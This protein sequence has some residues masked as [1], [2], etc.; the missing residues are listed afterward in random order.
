MYISII[1]IS[2]NNSKRVYIYIYIYICIHTHFYLVSNDNMEW[3]E[4]YH[5]YTRVEDTTLKLLWKRGCWEDV[6]AT[7]FGAW[8]CSM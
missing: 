8:S 7:M 4:K 6:T 1:H 3:K 2:H 5:K